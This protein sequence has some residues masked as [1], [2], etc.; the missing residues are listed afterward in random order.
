[1]ADVGQPQ[2]M[3]VPSVPLGCTQPLPAFHSINRTG[4]G[5]TEGSSLLHIHRA[6]GQAAAAPWHREGK[7]AGTSS[8]SFLWK[9]WWISW[10][11]GFKQQNLPFFRSQLCVAAVRRE[12]C[13]LAFASVPGHCTTVGLELILHAWERTQAC[14]KPTFSYLVFFFFCGN[15]CMI[16]LIFHC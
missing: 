10:K 7:N 6:H 1:M 16:Y 14:K 3:A 5:W 8:A 13:E 2:D 12:L 11:E 4:T 9:A 15:A